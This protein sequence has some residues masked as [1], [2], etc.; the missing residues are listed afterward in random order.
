MARK[1]IIL[2]GGSGTRLYPITHVVSKQLLPV[3]DKPMIYYP[4]STL[5]VAGIRD[6]LIISTPH[7]TPRFEAML[8]DGSQWGM[9]IQ[10]A[11]QPSPDGLA[12]AF[13]IG[14]S[15]I[16]N[17]PSALILGDN[18]FYGHDLAK[19]LERADANTNGATVFAYHV[20]DPERYGV[21]EFDRDFRALSIEEKPV[22]PRSHYAVTGLY[23]Y[24]NR[25]CDIASDIKPS[26]RGELEITDVNSR[27]L[28]DGALD[29]EIMGRGYAWLDTGTHDSLIDAAMFIATL[30]K[31]QGLVVACPEEIAYRK[32]WIDAEQLGKLAAPL[33]KNSYGRY[34]QHIL[35][36]QVAWPSR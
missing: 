11:V 17:E 9:N 28:A 31:R 13:I 20:Q 1:G 24:D 25:V 2:A 33:S 14:K 6:V 30:Q 36:D 34:L 8:G 35:S 18:I 10:F 32:R 15:F 7:D 5:M 3:Y 12:Q 16:G 27:Y 21:V 4:L 23:F 29:V 26:P 22:K 19:Q